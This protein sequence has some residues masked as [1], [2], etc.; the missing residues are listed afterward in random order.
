VSCSGTL[1]ISGTLV[2]F[3]EGTCAADT[4]CA[5]PELPGNLLRTK[6]AAS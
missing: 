4:G 5:G 2:I 1:F 3:A 6:G